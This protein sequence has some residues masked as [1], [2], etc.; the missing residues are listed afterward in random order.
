MTAML[1]YERTP[2]LKYVKTLAFLYLNQDEKFIKEDKY[3]I[4]Y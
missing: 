2:S 1:F 3:F 4:R